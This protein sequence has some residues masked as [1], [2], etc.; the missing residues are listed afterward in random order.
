M[1]PDVQMLRA[2]ASASIDGVDA[3]ALIYSS[4]TYCSTNCGTAVHNA[5]YSTRSFF[6]TEHDMRVDL[7]ALDMVIFQIYKLKAQS[8]EHPKQAR[9]G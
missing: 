2:E 3:Q 4:Q 8:S 9:F 1:G 6:P 7:F 5:Y